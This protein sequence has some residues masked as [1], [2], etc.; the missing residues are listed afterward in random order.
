[1]R[2]A[3]GQMIV[4]GLMHSAATPNA[5]AGDINS[6]VARPEAAM[7]WTD[8]DLPEQMGGQRTTLM[9]AQYT[10]VLP[11]NLAQLWETTDIKDTREYLANGQRNPTFGQ[12]ISRQK[13]KLDRNA[14]LVVVGGPHDG[15]PMT[16]TW[17]TNPRPRGKKDDQ[18]TPWI[19]DLAYVLEIGLGDKSRPGTPEA[20][21]AAINKYAGKTIRLETGLTGQCRPDKIRYVQT[22][23]DGAAQNI[24]DPSGTKGCGKRYYTKEFKNPDAGQIDPATKQAIPPYELEIACDCGSHPTDA[25]QAAGAQPLPEG[26]SVII[27]GFEQVERI[28]PPLG[29]AK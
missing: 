13:L 15:E 2:Y 7:E 20:L 19:S 21:K 12:L 11:G 23:I 10:F 9:P 18:K 22:Y 17:T 16:V 28:L 8:G 26:S 4:E 3:L 27:R 29:Q 14:P 5:P 6:T 1:M 25:Q 24:Q